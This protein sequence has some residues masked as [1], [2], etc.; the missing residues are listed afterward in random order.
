MKIRGKILQSL[1]LSAVACQ[2]SVSFSSCKEEPVDFQSNECKKQPAFLRT[3]G[4]DPSRAAYSTSEKNKMGLVL[5]QLNT[6]G[7]T[8]ARKIFQR[9]D[10]TM[11]GRLGPIQLDREGNCFVAPVPMI[12]MLDNPVSKQNIVYRVDTQNGE[13]KV[14][15]ELPEQKIAEEN[16]YGI[17]GF[18]Y[19]CETN[20]L[21]VSTVQGST[22]ETESGF[23]YAL[24]AS[25]GKV[26]DKISGI[27]AIGMGIS[28]ISG[29]RRL[30]FGSA[31]I[32][33]IFSILLNK[34]G[35]FSGKP[36]PA[37]SIA[38]LGPRGDDKVRRIK[39]DKN[40][41]M[42]VIGIEFNFNLTAPTEKQETVYTLYWNEAEKKW[43]Y[44]TY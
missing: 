21:Y 11:G 35:K 15:A 7:D 10:W 43:L 23:I 22:R 13:M 19:L 34:E 25:T 18:A 44:Q 16:P 41:A 28:Y 6:A 4:L 1:F 5:L 8:S 12:S 31:R 14:F 36:Q 26:I 40:G 27:D 24:D 20:T 42:Q 38:G 17:L 39:F 32:S 9:P 33:D 30:Y 29:E 2:L 3:T 37:F